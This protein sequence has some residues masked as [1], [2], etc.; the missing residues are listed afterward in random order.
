MDAASALTGESVPVPPALRGLHGV[1]GLA[2]D[3]RRIAYPDAA[4]RS[5]WWSPSLRASPRRIVVAR[6][7][8]HV[9]NS[10]QI[11]S[12]YLGFGIQ[13][14]VFVGDTKARRYL[15]IT[16]H[17]GWT[18]VDRT[19]LLVLFATGGKQIHAVAPIAFVPLRELPPMP[20]CS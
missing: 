7:A 10:V 19:S 8:N 3:G 6:G 2:T 15:K 18:R 13:P 11:G 4:Y 12:R 9:D 5:L 14:R 17:G 16:D 1:S 20:A